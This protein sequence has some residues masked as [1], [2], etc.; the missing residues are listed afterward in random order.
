MPNYW[1]RTLM[2]CKYLAAFEELIQQGGYFYRN[3][4]G[5]KYLNVEKGH[6]VGFYCPFLYGM[7]KGGYYERGFRVPEVF[8]F[9]MA[10]IDIP[11]NKL[12]PTEAL[13]LIKSFREEHPNAKGT[14]K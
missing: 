5:E 8:A 4:H 6:A 3:S 10:T 9:S 12:T 7:L 14:D 11:Y 1:G 13:G 2:A